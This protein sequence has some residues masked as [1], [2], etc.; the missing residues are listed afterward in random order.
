MNP[1]TNQNLSTLT[2]AQMMPR[3]ML[4]VGAFLLG[5]IMTHVLDPYLF[6]SLSNDK[7]GYA[8]GLTAGKSEGVA[9]TKATFDKSTL[10]QSVQA[11]SVANAKTVIGKVE[12]V[13]D[14]I[15]SIAVANTDPFITTTK[16]V[17]VKI[18]PSTVIASITEKAP[19]SNK[20]GTAT[21]SFVQG[22]VNYQDLIT[23][24]YIT[25]A[26]IHVGEQVTA[27]TNKTVAATGDN[28]AQA[29][30]I[31]RGAQAQK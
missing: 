8:R 24:K 31:S 20:K 12:S 5:A 28:E 16:V 27:F 7:A 2:S 18:L 25:L 11:G 17:R 10:G 13:S 15:L 23:V 3:I 29:V 22:A 14:N 9:Q 26:D 1:E 4:G 19:V 6:A 21:A 30:Q